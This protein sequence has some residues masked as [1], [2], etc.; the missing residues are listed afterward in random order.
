MDSDNV[1]QNKKEESIQS[2]SNA[3]LK[4][5]K[6]NYFI[7]NLFDYLLRKKGLEIIKYNKKSQKKLNISINPLNSPWCRNPAPNM[8]AKL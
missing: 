5:I 2:Q 8:E 4:N 3:D 6:S 1:T 7:Q